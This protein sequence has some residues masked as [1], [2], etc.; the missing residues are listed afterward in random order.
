MPNPDSPER[1]EWNEEN[2]SKVVAQLYR[3]AESNE[4]LHRQL[5]ND[6]YSVLNRRIEVPEGYQGGI[7]ARERSQRAMVMYVPAYGAARE[8]LPEGTTAID[9]P[10]DYDIVCT[11]RPPW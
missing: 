9:Q 6:P 2:L 11:V 5:M 8:E 7:F 3:E 10:P 1:V 4:A